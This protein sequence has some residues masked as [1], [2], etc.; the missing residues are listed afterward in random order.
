MNTKFIGNLKIVHYIIIKV[1]MQ[2]SST[3][4][5]FHRRDDPK[6]AKYIQTQRDEDNTYT[7][8]QNQK[9]HKNPIPHIH[10]DGPDIYL[11]IYSQ[12]TCQLWEE[13]KS[14]VNNIGVRSLSYK[15]TMLCKL[16]VNGPR[17][18][19]KYSLHMQVYKT[20]HL[21]RKRIE[22]N[23]KG[24]QHKCVQPIALVI[25]HLSVFCFDYFILFF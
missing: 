20:F 10:T 8:L 24:S 4:Y 21:N 23:W 11:T 18:I 3:Y 5:T 1:K 14:H 16:P 15:F 6:R 19:F 25:S 22:R 9:E 2:N 7:V 17:G 12:E 13:T